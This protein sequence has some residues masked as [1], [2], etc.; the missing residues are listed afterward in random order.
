VM[1]EVIEGSGYKRRRR[2]RGKV[3]CDERACA[4][5]AARSG[6]NVVTGLSSHRSEVK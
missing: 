5:F 2:G 3:A 1:M 6:S 4:G